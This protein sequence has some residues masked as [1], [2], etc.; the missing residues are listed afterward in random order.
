MDL[1]RFFFASFS[2]EA[3]SRKSHVGGGLFAGI[4]VLA[5]CAHSPAS[6]PGNTVFAATRDSLMPERSPGPKATLRL[7]GPPTDKRA[8]L[9]AMEF[10]IALDRRTQ[11]SDVSFDI[12]SD[13]ETLE[14]EIY[15]SKPK[16][17]RVV[18]AGDDTFAPP[19][20]LVRYPVREGAAWDWQGKVVYA[21]IS[22]E[23]HADVAISRDGDDVRS[24]VTL[25]VSADPN[26]PEIKRSLAFW[27]RK[28]KGVVA[29][30]FG[31]ASSR[32]PVGEPWRP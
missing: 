30:S 19:L 9:S 27:F 14:R 11:G 17:F 24:G 23:A 3:P 16:A 10:E 26:R 6:K 13:G 1:R 12:R 4:L 29:R 7:G 8:A 5:G 18:S 31:D 22:R 21:G 15:E 2:P 25:L 32:R 28:G 20:D